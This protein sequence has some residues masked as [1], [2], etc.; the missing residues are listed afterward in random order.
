MMGNWRMKHMIMMR[1]IPS[2]IHHSLGSVNR[3]H[4]LNGASLNLSAAAT[5]ES[6]G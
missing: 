6:L 3:L 2:L 4:F 1:P 5:T